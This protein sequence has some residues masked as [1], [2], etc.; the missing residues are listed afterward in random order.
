MDTIRSLL[1]PGRLAEKYRSLM[2]FMFGLLE[3][4]TESPNR[5]AKEK[6]ARERK[7]QGAVDSDDSEPESDEE[8]VADSDSDSEAEADAGVPD[9]DAIPKLARTT[10]VRIYAVRYMLVR[11]PL[12]IRLLS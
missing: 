1:N 2:P 12:V 8:L 5:Y 10:V 7:A 9:Y 6:A 3:V 11:L 4:F